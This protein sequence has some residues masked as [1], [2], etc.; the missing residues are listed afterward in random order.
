M[1]SVHRE[2]VGFVFIHVAPK[3]SREIYQN[4]LEKVFFFQ[5]YFRFGETSIFYESQYTEYHERQQQ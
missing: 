2:I 3:L 5:L 1:E 4:P